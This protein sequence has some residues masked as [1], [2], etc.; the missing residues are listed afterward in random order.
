MTDILLFIWVLPMAA[1]SVATI[2]LLGVLLAF[3]I[4]SFKEDW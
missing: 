4:K 3:L 2:I 1:C